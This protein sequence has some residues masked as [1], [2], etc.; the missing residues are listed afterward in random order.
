[1]AGLLHDVLSEGVKA[2]ASDIHIK[3][4]SP[5]HYRIAGTLVDCNFIPDNEFLTAVIHEMVTD[6]E[7]LASYKQ[8]GDLDISYVEEDVGRFRVNIHKERGGKCLTL[9]HVKDRIM[10]VAE[11]RLPPVINQIAEERRG[12]IILAGTTGSGKSTT[13]AA[14]LQ[15]IN[16]NFNRHVITIED[17]IE[18]EF[19]D[20]KSF[21]EQREIGIDTSSFSSALKHSLRQDPDIIMVGEMRDKH[22]FESALQ[23]ADTGHLVLTTL[24]SSTAS[25]TINRILDFYPKT[26]QDPI[27]EAL[28]LNLRAII[29]QRLMPVVTGDGVVPA[30]EIMINNASIKKMLYENQLDKLHTII[31]GGRHEGMQTFNQSL[32]DLLNGGLITEEDALAF[33]NNPDQLRMN[34]KGIFLGGES[35]ITG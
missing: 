15:Y 33:S 17:P 6:P 23:A 28:S 13:L 27:R 18:Y 3:E 24:H 7:Y 21:F 12:I 4:N 26:E 34:L 20:D 35:Q 31:E 8:H 29:A 1:M 5:I 14:I 16:E 19:H 9:R 25:Q 11:L 32:M 30:A 22:S 10:N 2:G